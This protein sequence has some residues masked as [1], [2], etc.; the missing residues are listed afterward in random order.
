MAL[1]RRA[2]LTTLG[3]AATSTALGSTAAA[4]DRSALDSDN[5]WSVLVDT[6]LCIGCRK[7]EWACNDHHK[8]SNRPLVTYEDKTV[9][10]Q[11]RRPDF[12]TYTVVNEFKNASLG[13]AQAIK[14]QCM[15]CNRPACASACIV[16]AL[17]KDSRGPVVYDSWKCI[18][19]RYCMVACPFQVPAYE[20]GNA[21]TPQVRKCNFCIDRLESGQVPACVSICPNETLTFGRRGDLLEAARSRIHR[22]N[23]RYVP[24]IYGETEGGGTAWLY[25]AGTEFAATG[26]P[27]LESEPVPEVT[28]WIQHGIFRSFVPPLALYALLGIIMHSTRNDTPGKQIESG[29][30]S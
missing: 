24:H 11:Q 26:L 19:C 4:E 12:D 5:Q 14:V 17:R 13:K 29:G 28:E 7:C 30:D 25:L 1:D 9:F 21:L 20:Y 10:A 6:V 23:G 18:G 27:Q 8:L 3:V 16:G 2:F 22:N 15:H